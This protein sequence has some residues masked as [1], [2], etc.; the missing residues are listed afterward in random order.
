MKQN[1]MPIFAVSSNFP[2]DVLYNRSGCELFFAECPV[3]LHGEVIRDYKKSILTKF[4]NK[5]LYTIF[6]VLRNFSL[7]VL[8]GAGSKL[9]Y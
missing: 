7:D 5:L 9:H 4:K 2:L 3:H 6:A 1:L 8:Y